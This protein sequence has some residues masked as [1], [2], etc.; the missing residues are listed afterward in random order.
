MKMRTRIV[1]LFL[2]GCLLWGTASVEAAQRRCGQEPGMSRP[3]HQVVYEAQKLYDQKQYQKALE[4]LAEYRRRRPGWDHHRLA[5]FQGVLA[6]QLG[7]LRQAEACFQ[8]AIKLWPCFGEA[9]RNLAAVQYELKQP[10]KAAATALDA[11]GIIKPPRPELAYL[12]AVCYLSARRPRQALPILQ[13]LAGLKKAKK[14]WLVALVRTHLELKQWKPARKVVRRLLALDGGDARFWRLLAG[15]EVRRRRYA[16][17]AAALEVGLRLAGP[18]KGDWRNLAE[19]YRAA[20]APL[21][22]AACYRRAFGDSPLAKD[23]ALLARVYLQ[24]RHLRE[25]LDAA[26]RAVEQKPSGRHLTLL[27][28]ILLRRRDYAEAMKCFQQAAEKLAGNKAARLLLRGAYC[29]LRLERLKLAERCLARALKLAKKQSPTAKE[30]R[31]TLAAVKQRL[32]AEK[33]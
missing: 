31:R 19:L 9:L 3:V 13:K 24:A 33:G 32:A 12:A 14:S 26:R 23:W 17:A 30:V 25:A 29:A 7:H 21:K 16:Q 28:E 5:F 1:I 10:L 11:Y 22:A 8:R 27:A 18:R 2:F 4:H 20:G 15:L 6:Y